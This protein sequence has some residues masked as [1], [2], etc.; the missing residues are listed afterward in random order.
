M[1][2]MVKTKDVEDAMVK[3]SS[4]SSSSSSLLVVGC[5]CRRSATHGTRCLPL[6]QQFEKLTDKRA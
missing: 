6:G 4:S 3:R 2:G 1:T 5:P